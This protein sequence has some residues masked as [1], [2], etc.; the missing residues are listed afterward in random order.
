MDSIVEFISSIVLIFGWFTLTVGAIGSIV[1]LFLGG[2][3]II[4]PFLVGVTGI[5]GIWISKVLIGIID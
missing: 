5:I 3:W 4:V 1:S 2:I